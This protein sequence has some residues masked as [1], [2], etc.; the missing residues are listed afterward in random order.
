MQTLKILRFNLKKKRTFNLKNDHFVVTGGSSG[1]GLAIA[2]Q[3]AK[4]G[5]NIT[6]VARSQERLDAAK[7]KIYSEI[8][9]S[10]QRILT[11]S[12]DISID[13]NLKDL[14]IEAE[15]KAGP[16]TVLINCAGASVCS[17][18]EDTSMEDFKKM[19]N[20]NFLG[21][22]NMTQAVVP[23]MKKRKHGHI[24]FV[25]SL[26]GLIGIYGYSAYSGSKF[27]V[28]GAAQA[29]QMEVKTYNISITVSF[30]P[31][32]D[33]PGFAEE[34][35]NKP[36]ETIRISESA[37]LYSAE[38]VAKQTLNDILNKK[39]MSTIGFDGLMLCT[40]CSATM[41]TNSYFEL[42][43]Q[44]FTMG[45]LRLASFVYLK[46]CDHTIKKCARDKEME[47]KKTLQNE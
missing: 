12:A 11:F 9:N 15:K 20:V 3:A 14:V 25:S 2:I 1:I 35:K 13:N 40:A 24:A 18:F 47:S 44:I 4:M 21:S 6:I 8:K 43:V 23:L 45:I 19:L 5:A 42:L 10:E 22:I 38:D 27:A 30:P 16:I 46:Q 17:C 41:P 36:I 32:T 34:M 31:D 37:G 33:T 7:D 29:L 39:F 28:L 26:A